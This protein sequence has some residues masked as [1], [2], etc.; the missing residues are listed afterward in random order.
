MKEPSHERLRDATATRGLLSVIVP[1]F[2]EASVIVDLHRRLSA[3][4]EA[5]AAMDF[6]LI[7][8]DD[9]STDGTLELLRRIQRRAPQVRVLALSRN[10][11]QENA[12][13]AGLQ[14]ASGDAVV[15]IDADL[16]DPPEVIPDMI[17]RW[18]A[19]ADVVYGEREERQGET[20][21]KRWLA[22]V[23]YRILARTATVP[24]PMDVGC[25][26]I[27]DRKVADALLAMPEG[28][29]FFRGMVTWVGFRQ[30]RIRFRR[31][32]RA[33]GSSSYGMMRMLRLAM[34]AILSFSLLPVRLAVGL[35]C[36]ATGLAVT[37]AIGIA[38]IGLFT[39]EWIG[40]GAALAIAL[41]FFGGGQLLVL[42]LIGELAGRTYWE[43]KRR[44][45]YLVKERIGFPL[46]PAEPSSIDSS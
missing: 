25:F 46:A 21:L 27:I 40:V 5:V 41:L 39:G 18:R 45:L 1:C 4:L 44:P 31:A 13:T 3:V 12:I 15:I 6:E 37:G 28:D 42:A 33:A 26:R 24:I 9:G 34:D 32:A 35:G 43:V 14:H 7:Y 23:F 36:A 2:N 19:G 16:Q 30:E 17:E 20:A 11:G 8:V 38:L 29:R 10:F 22:A